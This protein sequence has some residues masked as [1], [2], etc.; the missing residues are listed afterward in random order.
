M[1]IC[2]CC[3][4]SPESRHTIVLKMAETDSEGCSILRQMYALHCIVL[5]SH[6]NTLQ[7]HNN[8]ERS[9]TMRNVTKPCI[10]LSDL[11]IN[12][13]IRNLRACLHGV[14]DPVLVGL[15][16]FVFTLWGTQNK[17]NLPH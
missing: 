7:K 16:S 11:T 8:K 15:V 12:S 3:A 6:Y 9:K 2:S 4:Q 13:E 14:G 17:R 5:S 10:N 1:H